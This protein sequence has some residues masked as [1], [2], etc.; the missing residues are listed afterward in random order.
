M[1]A[2][3]NEVN[4][5]L[6]PSDEE[7][8]Y[9][10]EK[11]RKIANEVCSAVHNCKWLATYLANGIGLVSFIACP[12]CLVFTC[13]RSSFWL[14]LSLPNYQKRAKLKKM[15]IWEKT[16]QASRLATTK[17]IKCKS[18]C[19]FRPLFAIT[20]FGCFTLLMTCECA[21]PSTTRNSEPE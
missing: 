1:D 9:L 3:E 5:F 7:V 8:F 13:E 14:L 11:E 18:I 10:R 21:S 2:P 6:L 12:L 20:H 19:V 4:P 16:T 15:K 17:S